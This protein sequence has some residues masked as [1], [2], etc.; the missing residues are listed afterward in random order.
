MFSLT[1]MEDDVWV[2]FFKGFGMWG[3]VDSCI[4]LILYL[5][6]YTLSHDTLTVMIFP[7]IFFS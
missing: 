4:C 1:L 7:G 5:C 3:M 6:S 2:H